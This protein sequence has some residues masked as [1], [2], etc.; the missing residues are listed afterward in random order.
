[1]SKPKPH[2]QLVFS[3]ASKAGSGESVRDEK[4]AQRAEIELLTKDFL[5]VGGEI[6]QLESQQ[7]TDFKPAWNGAG[8]TL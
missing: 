3:R 4:R 8:D 1:M 7:R 5:S 2:Q 6:Q